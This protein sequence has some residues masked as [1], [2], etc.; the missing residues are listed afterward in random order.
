MPPLEQGQRIDAQHIHKDRGTI[1]VEPR[2]DASPV[3]KSV[4]RGSVSEMA[5]T[6]VRILTNPAWEVPPS[7]KDIGVTAARFTTEDGTSWETKVT[8][9]ETTGGEHV[10]LERRGTNGNPTERIDLINPFSETTFKPTVTHRSNEGVQVDTESALNSATT[11]I[12]DFGELNG[13]VVLV[14][15]L[16]TRPEK[17]VVYSRP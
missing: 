3:P 1:A 17:A 6:V 9:L 15:N 5:D 8:K 4:L 10:L 11:L 7:S 2:P 14:E 16:V 12:A 13:D